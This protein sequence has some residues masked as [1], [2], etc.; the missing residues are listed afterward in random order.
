MK[1]EQIINENNWTPEDRAASLQNT[2]VA[3]IR[4]A[5]D[6]VLAVEKHNKGNMYLRTKRALYGVALNLAETALMSLPAETVAVLESQADFMEQSAEHLR[7]LAR[8]AIAKATETQ[9]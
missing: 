8:A 5:Y 1:T 7:S 6:A 2:A 3:A 9:E 4:D